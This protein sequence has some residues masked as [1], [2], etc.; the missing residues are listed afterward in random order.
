MGLLSQTRAMAHLPPG[1]SIHPARFIVIVRHQSRFVYFWRLLRSISTRATFIAVA[2]WLSAKFPSAKAL[3]TEVVALVR[4]QTSSHH[5]IDSPLFCDNLRVCNNP[6]YSKIRAR[7]GELCTG[8]ANR[9]RTCDAMP[10]RRVWTLHR[11][12]TVPA[13][14]G[15]ERK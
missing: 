14:E 11:S 5:S 1:W 2:V 12:H 6:K 13:Q 10:W 4:I 8:A 9:R 15:G 7:R 3:Q